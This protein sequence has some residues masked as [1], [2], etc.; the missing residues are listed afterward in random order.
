[1]CL[2]PSVLAVWVSFFLSRC[3]SPPL[4]VS[5]L[6]PFSL[7]HSVS[8]L[9]FFCRLVSLC[10]RLSFSRLW[11]QRERSRWEHRLLAPWNL[12][13]SNF[14]LPAMWVVKSSRALLML[15]RALLMW[16]RALL[17]AYRAL[18]IEYSALLM[19]YRALLI[20]YTADLWK[21]RAHFDRRTPPPPL[22]RVVLLFGWFDLK[23][24]RER[25]QR[26]TRF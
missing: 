18:L 14:L 6:F 2:L 8:L 21:Y 23:S 11:L 9:L 19:E 7:L 13:A 25:F 26:S 16:Y 5:L 22:P 17:V 24:R 4:S 10:R 20:V 12:I 3:V 1:M 15:Y